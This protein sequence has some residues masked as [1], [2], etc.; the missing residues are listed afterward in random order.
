MIRRAQGLRRQPAANQNPEPRPLP[1]DQRVRALRRRVADRS[2]GQQERLKVFLAV[3]GAG[4]F[5]QPLKQALGQIMRRSQRLRTI[6][7]AAIDDAD[8]RQCSAVIDIDELAGCRVAA[9]PG[10][11]RRNR[12]V[13]HATSP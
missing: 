5:L 2:R 1:L 9:L 12:W 4:G 10:T 8:I 11:N 13:L 7:C 6:H 3:D